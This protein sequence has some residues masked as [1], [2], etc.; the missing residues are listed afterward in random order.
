MRKKIELLSRA[1]SPQDVQLFYQI[2]LKGREDLSLAPNG[3]IGMEMIV[4]RMMAFRPAD[5][6]QANIILRK[7]RI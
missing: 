3:R 1:L 7:V 6:S 2:A 4:L 5:M